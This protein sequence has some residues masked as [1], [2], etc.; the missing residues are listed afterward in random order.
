M[1]LWMSFLWRGRGKITVMSSIIKKT[2]V[3]CESR[4]DDEHRLFDPWLSRRLR[5][6]LERLAI[7]ESSVQ[8]KRGWSNGTTHGKQLRGDT[9]LANPLIVMPT[10]ERFYRIISGHRRKYCAEKL[11]YTKGCRLLSGIWKK[12]IQSYLWWIR[13]FWGKDQIRF[14]YSSTMDTRFCFVYQLSQRWWYDLCCKIQSITCPDH[15]GCSSV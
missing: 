12:M 13:T 1:V 3:G 10:T 4:S 2:H 7:R 6:G 11:G 14:G 9:E 5:L 8:G 15:G